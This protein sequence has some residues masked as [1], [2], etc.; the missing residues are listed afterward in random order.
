MLM[1]RD[2]KDI[3]PIIAP[4]TVIP[5][6]EPSFVHSDEH[7]FCSDPDCPCHNEDDYREYIGQYLDNGMMTGAEGLRRYWDQ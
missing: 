3:A 4:D 1:F 2:E 5:Q 7:P 6:E